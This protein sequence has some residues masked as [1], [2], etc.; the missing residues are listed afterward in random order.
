MYILLSLHILTMIQSYL[1]AYIIQ[2]F[3]LS[4]KNFMQLPYLPAADD[5]IVD[6]RWIVFVVLGNSSM[7]TLCSVHTKAKWYSEAPDT[8]TDIV[9]NVSN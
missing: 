7:H 8:D 5:L 3:Q 4:N 1:G 2:T 6:S 9:T